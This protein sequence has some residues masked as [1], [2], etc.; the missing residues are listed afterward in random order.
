ML[1]DN[2][3][4]GSNSADTLSR[5]RGT[6]DGPT[7]MD[8]S[9][10]FIIF[11][12]ERSKRASLFGALSPDNPEERVFVSKGCMDRSGFSPPL[13][14]FRVPLFDYNDEET[15]VTF[16]E[17]SLGLEELLDHMTYPKDC[18]KGKRERESVPSAATESATG[19]RSKT[20]DDGKPSA[21]DTSSSP[22]RSMDH[23]TGSAREGRDQSCTD[24]TSQ[25][26]D[27]RRT[28]KRIPDFHGRSSQSCKVQVVFCDQDRNEKATFHPSERIYVLLTFKNPTQSDAYV[29]IS[30]FTFQ[31]GP[32]IF[33]AVDGCQ[34]RNTSCRYGSRIPMV[35]IPPVKSTTLS[36][37]YVL[38]APDDERSTAHTRLETPKNAGDYVA[39]VKRHPLSFPDPFPLRF[40]GRLQHPHPPLA[41]KQVEESRMVVWS[42]NH[43][44]SFFTDSLRVFGSSMF[45]NS[46]IRLF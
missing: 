10:P 8:R 5:Y 31:R 22:R 4:C 24:E 16:T 21:R 36:F 42:H 7:L 9:T 29:K 18:P 37:V 41:N 19:K 11:L 20:D 35:R 33:M 40:K 45:I 15:D 27:E 34:M 12:F 23:R 44:P 39:R 13:G 38:C 26:R 2:R 43:F 14:L 1:S 28:T 30:K 3:T 32:G 17:T 25:D 46:K 6:D